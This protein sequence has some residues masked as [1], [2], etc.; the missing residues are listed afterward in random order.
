MSTG[1]AFAFVVGSFL[2]IAFT[3]AILSSFIH[4]YNQ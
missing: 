2:R 1:A 4:S 3:L